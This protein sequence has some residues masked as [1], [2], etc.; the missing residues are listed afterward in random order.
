MRFDFAATTGGT[1]LT[2]PPP[3]RAGRRGG[4]VPGLRPLR[5]HPLYCSLLLHPHSQASIIL[6]TMQRKKIKSL[7]QPKQLQLAPTALIPPGLPAD[8][9][10]S[11]AQLGAC[12][13]LLACFRRTKAW[14]GESNAPMRC[15]RTTFGSV[16]APP[17]ELQGPPQPK[18]S[19]PRICSKPPE[20]FIG[21]G[22][23]AR[24][25]RTLL[26]RCRPG[27]GRRLYPAAATRLYPPH[28]LIMHTSPH[29]CTH[30]PP[31]V[32]VQ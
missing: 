20:F 9:L 30:P 2:P 5:M 4:R 1:Q 7:K 10:R 16:R 8:S 13:R 17:Q 19:V 11:S 14:I 12:W 25:R 23:L 31:S 26:S 15:S 32:T 28:T 24:V 22:F 18:L 3:S 27:P 21:T 29:H 6:I